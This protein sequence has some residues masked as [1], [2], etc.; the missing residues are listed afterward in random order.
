[1]SISA[2][3]AIRAVD[4]NVS[5]PRFLPQF[6]AILVVEPEMHHVAVGDDVFLAFQTQLSSVAR[7]GLATERHV[8]GVSNRFGA[9][10][11]LLE[12]RM[13]DAGGRRRLGAAMDCPGTRLLRPDREI[14]D[15]VEQLVAG[16][17]QAIEA[18]LF[19]TQ[20]IEEILALLARQRRDLRFDLG[21]N[22][23][24]DRAFLFGALEYL[25]R[26]IIAVLC[27]AFLDVADVKH[28]LRC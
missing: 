26:E 9:N 11:A 2:Q 17:D 15:E 8:I 18:G 6:P 27:R 12:I 24:R 23:H 25:L 20:R 3:S 19:K 1:M 21:R 16:A 14:S 28:G 22:H 10:E 5:P 13:N 4:T 7:A